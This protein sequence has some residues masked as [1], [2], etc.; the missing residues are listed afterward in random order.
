MIAGAGAV[1]W[2]CAGGCGWVRVG[3]GVCT[4]V[5]EYSSSLLYNL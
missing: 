5:C 3:A 2:M 4:C 1:A